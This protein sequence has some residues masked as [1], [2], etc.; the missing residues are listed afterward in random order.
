[1]NL[2]RCRW[3]CPLAAA[4]LAMSTLPMGSAFALS[5]PNVTFSRGDVSA[6]VG[7]Y[8]QT[9]AIPV[10]PGITGFQPSVQFSYSSMGSNG[11][12]GMGWDMNTPHIER[13]TK[14]GAPAF[15]DADPFTLVMNGAAQTLIKIG[16]GEYRCSRESAFLKIVKNATGWV[17]NDPNGLTYY[18]GPK[19]PASPSDAA[20]DSVYPTGSAQPFSWWV[21]RIENPYGHAILYYYTYGNWLTKI[22]YGPID[23][24]GNYANRV[25]FTYEARD[26][27]P[28]LHGGWVPGHLGGRLDAVK[29]YAQGQLA[30]DF[31]FHYS[32]TPNDPRSLLTS[33]S[34]HAVDGS[35]ETQQTDFNYTG[36]NLYSL[37]QNWRQPVTSYTNNT[38][39]NN[40]TYTF[41]SYVDFDGDGNTEHIY[42]P[43]KATTF[44]I[45]GYPLPIPSRGDT[46]RPAAY[47]DLDGDGFMDWLVRDPSGKIAAYRGRDGS[48]FASTPTLWN[49]P[50]ANPST[51]NF[52]DVNGDG[53]PDRIAGN[54][55][56]LNA[57]DTFLATATPYTPPAGMKAATTMGYLGGPYNTRMAWIKSW[58]QPVWIYLHDRWER[59]PLLTKVR[60]LNSGLDTTIAYTAQTVANYPSKQMYTVRRIA[61]QGSIAAPYRSTRYDY[62]GGTYNVATKE[63]RGFQQV[64]ATDEQSGFVTT[65]TYLQDVV[66]VGMPQNITVAAPSG[67][68]VSQTGN[69]W[70]AKNYNPT[71]ATPPT[72]KRQLPY[73]ES[74]STTTWDLQGAQTSASSLS[75]TYDNL[76]NLLTSTQLIAGG[77][78]SVTTNTYYPR[79][80]TWFLHRLHTTSTTVTAPDG[81]AHTRGKNFVYN[82]FGQL[83][84]E[85]A[86]PN[87]AFVRHQVFSYDPQGNLTRLETQDANRLPLTRTDFTYANALFQQTATNSLGHTETYEYDPRFGVRTLLTGPNGLSTGWD[88]DGFGRVIKET[89]PDGTA[90][91]I[92]YRLDARNGTDYWRLRV[93]RSETGSGSHT[94]YFDSYGRSRL[95]CQPAYTN[96]YLWQYTRYNTLGRVEYVTQ[97]YG[98]GI[99]GNAAPR[100]TYTYDILGRQIAITT[101]DGNVSRK[102]YLTLA[103]NQRKEVTTAPLGHTTT[104][105]YNANDQLT[106]VVDSAN[107][108]LTYTYDAAG[109]LTQTQDGAGNTTTMVYDLLGRKTQM[110]DPDMGTWQYTYTP[111][112][113]L[114]W[115]KDNAGHETT[116]EYDDLG[117]MKSRSEAEGASTWIYDT[118]WVGALSRETGPGGFARSYTHDG[119]GRT[120]DVTTTVA[121]K[122]YT[123]STTY[124]SAS[125][126][127]NLTYPNGRIT[128]HVY[129]ANGHLQALRN[130]KNNGLIWRADVVNTQGQITQEYFGNG[131]TTRRTFDP[132]TG[133]LTAIR[134]GS[135]PGMANVQDLAYGVDALGNLTYRENRIAG[136]HE[137][138]TYD[139]LNRLTE[140]L[141]YDLA[142][143]TTPSQTR[144][145]R[146]DA[147]GNLT[148]KSDA[149]PGGYVYDLTHPHQVTWANGNS[150]T[151][152]LNG[153]LTQGAGRTI[154]YTSFNQPWQIQTA[155][156][157]VTYG[158]DTGHQRLTRQTLDSR[159]VYI[160]KLF[161][162]TTVTPPGGTTIVKQTCYLYAAGRLVAQV[163]SSSGVAL[164]RYIHTDHLGSPETITN[165]SGQIIE[166]LDFDPF[167][168]PTTPSALLSRGFTGHEMEPD[169]GLINMNARMYDP[170]L[171]RFLQADTVV[172]NP[173]N[174][175]AYNRYSY[176]LNNPLAYT[177]PSGHWPNWH[178]PSWLSSAWKKAKPVLMVVAQAAL[179]YYCGPILAG[180]I[181]GGITGG[182]Q[183]A[184]LGAIAGSFAFGAGEMVANCGLGLAGSAMAFG[185]SGGI[186]NTMYG[187]NFWEGFGMA[188]IPM[189]LP[190]IGH[191]ADS[192]NLLGVASDAAK[193]GMVARMYG[194]SFERGAMI[195]GVSS[196]TY[197]L[198][199]F[200]KRGTIRPGAMNGV[201]PTPWTVWGRKFVNG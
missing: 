123:V 86:D 141:R 40:Y 87:T 97:P 82:P 181:M 190:T 88:L 106:R 137:D 126:V 161:E 140:A 171:G 21:S 22:A 133:A 1:M 160:G 77:S 104:Q 174:L 9:I 131:L 177:D 175:Q 199:R 117:R 76:G 68:V 196:M 29:T 173:G 192:Y 31:R 60:N 50:A 94:E 80:T 78:T 107:G 136:W 54:V 12:M 69:V 18:L 180:A 47:I 169:V 149:G 32:Q 3:L 57:G 38:S 130:G 10:P 105:F 34:R 46:A 36:H 110:T 188:A 113:Q 186:T 138:F 99:N 108:T 153:N 48:T 64:V 53:L 193:G 26:D 6:P 167:G 2:R 71:A 168:A 109:N 73:L 159:T 30:A 45:N 146:Y 89:R 155:S 14:N 35:G 75:Q 17:V 81:S 58:G 165:A 132:N 200:G 150:Y 145:Y 59:R 197:N 4:V 178:A 98:S 163:E 79:G 195:A 70:K 44:Q 62:T 13:S 135:A 114:Q 37:A 15:T 179:T 116:M 43:A 61:T 20:Q 56:Y 148:Y 162:E 121:G 92:A 84:R 101:P 170:A 33:V 176:V 85:I 125:R 184:C 198:M 72:Y 115:Q 189:M 96:G 41:H 120:T 166:T 39:D 66:F 147:I 52:A 67:A 65:T 158:Y 194:Q 119:L 93:V 118:L 139:Q 102:D 16:P 95:K 201:D 151:Y 183:G 144:S 112:G 49:D 124:D 187:G 191:G 90:T 24:S 164:I 111:L 100:T 63:F 129:T 27:H 143:L 182:V 5:G 74:S 7:S 128:R 122:D 28:W 156:A 19:D 91:N 8:S 185:T 83:V 42:F 172:P 134:T 152:D 103:G 55:A 154:A 142:N 127:Q 157:T 23:A 11:R 51:M 25:D